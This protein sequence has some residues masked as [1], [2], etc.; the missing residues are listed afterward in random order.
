[1][2]KKSLILIAYIAIILFCVAC[3]PIVIPQLEAPM[4]QLDGN[5]AIWE[6]NEHADKFEISISGTLFY[7]ENSVTSYTLID[8]QTFK[9]RA[10]GDGA[11][12]K[13]SEWSNLVEYTERPP[14]K[15]YTV[16]W[17]NGDNVIE[18]DEGVLYGSMPVYDGETP[19]KDSTVQYSYEFSGWMPT[20]APVTQ[21]ITYYAQFSE[22]IVYYNVTFYDLDRVTVLKSEKVIYGASANPP[23]NIPEKIDFIFVGWDADYS[24]V[25]NDLAIYPIYSEVCEVKFYMPDGTKIGETQKVKKFDSAQEPI[26]PEYCEIRSDNQATILKA[27]SGWDKSFSMVTSDLNITAKYERNTGVVL[28]VKV[29]STERGVNLNFHI[30]SDYKIEKENP[31]EQ[32][33]NK[34]LYALEMLLSYETS[35]GGGNIVFNEYIPNPAGILYTNDEN[36][37]TDSVN[38]VFNNNEKTFNFAWSNAAGENVA[39]LDRFMTIKCSV[40]GGEVDFVL[41]VLKSLKCN[42]VI[43]GENGELET[44]EVNI[45][46]VAN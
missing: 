5:K 28:L 22:N 12:Y 19:T 35:V 16:T 32:M 10:I 25:T 6:A 23:T 7:L 8:G 20:L 3:T 14:Q 4:V 1:M 44:V 17:M 37:T 9:V 26:Y 43:D 45:V 15:T 31:E 46:F 40:S 21:N 11:T 30:Y 34:K 39:F 29:N 27:F 38:Y 42:A 13:T 2:K 24:N 18:K 36:Q 41:T 33:Q